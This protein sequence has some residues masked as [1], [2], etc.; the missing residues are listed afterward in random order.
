MNLTTQYQ[1]QSFALMSRL[2]FETLPVRVPEHAVRAVAKRVPDIA[3]QI[4][5]I[6]ESYRDDFEKAP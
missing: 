2:S 1:G 4:S 3:C 5:E 6:R